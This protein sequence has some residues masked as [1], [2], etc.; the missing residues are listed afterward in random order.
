[1]EKASLSYDEI[2][3]IY[4]ACRATKRRAAGALA[5]EIDYERNLLELCDELNQR[6]W[7][8]GSCNC[9]IV[10]KPVKRE[11]FAA[12]FKDRIVHHILIDKLNPCFERF[13]I[14]DSFACR[15]G[16][17]TLAAIKRL[18][19]FVN[20]ATRNCK[21]ESY[22]LKLDI[23]GYFMS[24]NRTLL[25]KKLERFI[26]TD[27]RAYLCKKSQEKGQ[28]KIQKGGW[29]FDLAEIEEKISFVTYLA[30]EI[31]FNDPTKQVSLKSPKSAWKGLPRDKSLF[32]AKQGCGLPIGNLTSQV[33][34]NFFLTEFDHYI[35]HTLG[36]KRYVRYVDDFVIVHESKSY[37]KYLIPKIRTFLKD[38]LGLTLHPRK[39][40][41]QEA[42][43]GVPFLGA[44][45]KPNLILAGKRIQKNFAQK[46]EQFE[47]L[48][49]DHKPSRNEKIAV[50]ASINSYLGI[51]RQ[52]KSWKLRVT[53]LKKHFAEHLSKHFGLKKNALKLEKKKWK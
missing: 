43:K 13:F 45:I 44:F 35:K 1:M 48:A 8:P 31:V 30:K 17:G 33:F 20:S 11:I 24:I 3:E 32:T 9:F 52:Y 21:K 26:Q 16:K 51:L 25:Y 39:I 46:S 36:I 53:V 47:R 7:K 28:G 23:K 15:T 38:E 19:H 42:K 10:E 5:F 12:P 34:A 41:L 14:K 37:L 50:L 29:I 18:S 6:R 40:Y 27:Y 22:I 49:H 2:F 4:F